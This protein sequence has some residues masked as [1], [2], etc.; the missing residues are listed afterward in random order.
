M[1]IISMYLPQYHRVKE[2]DEW[3][4][5]GFTD[6]TT[7]KNAVKFCDQQYQPR[8]PLNKNY[9]DL[10]QKETM[11][12]QTK[13]MKKYGI[14]AQCIYHYWFRDGR[15]ILESQLKIYCNGEMFICHFAFAG[16][17]KAGHAHGVE[18]VIKIHGPIRLKKREA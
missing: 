4:G 14:D 6:W 8:I 11:R 10:Q 3:W 1:K 15:Q 7:I 12:W 9:Y 2:N 13:L 17:M 16:R 18:S 5:E